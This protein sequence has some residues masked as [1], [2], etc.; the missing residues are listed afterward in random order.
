M[1]KKYVIIFIAVIFF[2]G[3]SRAGLCQT[4]HPRITPACCPSKSSPSA[5]TEDCFSHCAKQKL[6]II[7][8]EHDLETDV[9]TQPF[10]DNKSSYNLRS[11]LSSHSLSRSHN[12]DQIGDKLNISQI[13][14]FAIFNRA[15]PSPFNEPI[16]QLA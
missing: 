8:S 10:L 1:A 4:I 3:I 14:F 6:D 5:N 13:Y 16:K 9:K 15:P 7:K 2:L 12:L 11:C